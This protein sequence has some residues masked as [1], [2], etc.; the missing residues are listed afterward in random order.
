MQYELHFP[1]I[2]KSDNNKE[3]MIM[4]GGS[5]GKNERLQCCLSCHCE[6]GQ[7]T[8]VGMKAGTASSHSHFLQHSFSLWDY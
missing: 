2:M 3:I 5:V 4:T 8:S 6:F 7:K 1:G